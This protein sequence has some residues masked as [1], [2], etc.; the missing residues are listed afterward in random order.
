A[1]TW[2]VTSGGLRLWP[3][4]GED[5]GRSGDLDLDLVEGGL[6][7]LS[8]PFFAIVE[9]VEGAAPVERR[10]H[11]TG[12]PVVVPRATE[13]GRAEQRP[14]RRQYRGDVMDGERLARHRSGEAVDHQVQ[15]RRFE[16]PLD[17]ERLEDVALDRGDLE[18]TQL[19]RGV[20]EDVRVRIDERD[21]A[22]IGEP[23]AF[24]EPACPGSDIEM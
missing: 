21:P 11:A 5:R 18:P 6:E 17:R 2:F 7:D 14:G 1:S 22:A 10:Q 23:R 4:R 20:A 9:V 3:L 15:G 16:R 24:D 12:E 19:L 13:H 8:Q